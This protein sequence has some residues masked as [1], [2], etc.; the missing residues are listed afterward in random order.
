M[1]GDVWKK[2]IWQSQE[3]WAAECAESFSPITFFSDYSPR[4][5]RKNAFEGEGEGEEGGGNERCSLSVTVRLRAATFC[6]IITRPTTQPF[7]I[8]NYKLLHYA[9]GCL[10]LLF[11]C[12]GWGYVCVCRPIRLG[13]GSR[14]DGR[15]PFLGERWQFSSHITR[16]TSKPTVVIWCDVDS[17]CLGCCGWAQGWNGGAAGWPWSGCYGI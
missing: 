9:V 7:L 3:L 15:R 8:R 11:S 13:K 16:Q 14:A 10:S 5:G 1:R 2:G 6:Q 4:R 17:N 12:V